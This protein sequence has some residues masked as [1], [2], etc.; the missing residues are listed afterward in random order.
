MMVEGRLYIGTSGFTYNH[1]RD[2]FYPRELSE[3][4]WL[5]YYARHF[6]TVEIN[7]SFYHLPR[8]STCK[9]WGERVPENFLF[10]MKASRY[11][12]HIKKLRDIEEPVKNFFQVIH[13]LEKKLGPIL[14]QFPPGMKKDIPLLEDFIEKLPRGFCHVFEF[15][16]R[17]WF[18]DDLFNL[19]DNR[20][21]TF[22]IHDLPKR[23]TPYVET[24][25]FN[26]VRFHGAQAAYSSFYS[27]KELEKWA[28]RFIECTKTGK[29]VFSYFNND[30]HGYAIENAKT[31]K[32]ILGEYMEFHN[33]CSGD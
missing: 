7:S 18:E 2:V 10:A 32:H 27:E 14:F 16:N 5:E 13:S 29:D 9:N 6:S 26:Y 4:K 31:L 25:N 30:M 21:I 23:A 8:L 3:K 33:Y 28:R 17:T 12:T 1:W 22:C 19:L 24:G 20:G 15:R 11:I